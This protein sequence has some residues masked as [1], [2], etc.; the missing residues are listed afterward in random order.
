MDVDTNTL[1]VWSCLL[2]TPKDSNRNRGDEAM[3]QKTITKSG[4][5]FGGQVKKGNKHFHF[6]FFDQDNEYGVL[7]LISKSSRASSPSYTK[8]EDAIRRILEWGRLRWKSY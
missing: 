1:W 3:N 5:V 7:G 8:Q 6:D 2:A 4:P